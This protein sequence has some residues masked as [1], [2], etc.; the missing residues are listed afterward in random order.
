MIR[1]VRWLAVLIMALTVPA[2]WA[3]GQAAPLN[4]P[5][6]QSTADTAQA[7][8]IVAIAR[9]A[10]AKYDLKAVILRVTIDNK[11]VVTQAMGESMTGVPATSDMHFRNG[12]VA[13][14]YVSTLLLEL[15]DQNK[16]GLDDKLS[17]WFPDL[18]TPIRSRC[19]CWPT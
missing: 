17:N 19:G 18:T 14:S 2:A 3:P 13:I 7:A 10:I 5:V 8:A 16:V 11:E 12:A 1:R 4:Q 15:V 6:V 9:D